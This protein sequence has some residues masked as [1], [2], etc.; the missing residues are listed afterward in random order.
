LLALSTILCRRHL[1]IRLIIQT[2]RRDPSGADQIDEA[3]NV[4]R[5]D[6]SGPD[7]GPWRSLDPS[8]LSSRHTWP[9]S[10]KQTLSARSRSRSVESTEP[11]IRCIPRER[12]GPARAGQ[13]LRTS[14][15][16]KLPRWNHH[17]WGAA[18]N[19]S[20]YRARPGREAPCGP[21]FRS[22]LKPSLPLLILLRSLWF[23]TASPVINSLLNVESKG[24]I[25]DLDYV[26]HH[27]GYT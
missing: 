9:M 3:L 15:K 23:W 8:R 10:E 22:Y 18:V 12:R 25:E 7:P 24:K 20:R 4:S 2:I 21:S 13:T 5:P 26:V 27:D 17:R 14:E 11:D 6:P 19:S 16:I 1:I